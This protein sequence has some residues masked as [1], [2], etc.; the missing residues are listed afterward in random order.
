MSPSERQQLLEARQEVARLQTKSLR[1]A[2]FALVCAG[3]SVLCSLFALA[4]HWGW[5]R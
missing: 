5:I 3:I 2:I 4:V 1:W